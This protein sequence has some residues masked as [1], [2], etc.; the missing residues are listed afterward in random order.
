MKY[1]VTSIILACY[2]VAS[3]IQWSDKYHMARQQAKKENKNILLFIS[4]KTNPSCEYM[5]IDVFTNDKVV[6]L[7]NKDYIA[8]KIYDEKYFPKDLMF[9]SAPS[10]YFLTPKGK[11]F[12]KNYKWIVGEIPKR[13]LI[14]ILKTIK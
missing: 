13:K 10:L 9:Y 11:Y 14:E 2:L 8:V 5:E 3:S 4:S 6:K 12:A 7:I 1:F